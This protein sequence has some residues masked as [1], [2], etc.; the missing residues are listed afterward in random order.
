MRDGIFYSNKLKFFA[1]F[2]NKQTEEKISEQYLLL[3]ILESGI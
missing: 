1:Y 3:H 2:L